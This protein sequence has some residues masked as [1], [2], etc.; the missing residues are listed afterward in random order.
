MMTRFQFCSLSTR[1]LFNGVAAMVSAAAISL[2]V[3]AGGE[4]GGDEISSLPGYG[5]GSGVGS[6]EIPSHARLTLRAQSVAHLSQVVLAD[7]GEFEVEVHP[8][9]DG[10]LAIYSGDVQL[11]L[12]EL[13]LSAAGVEV[14]LLSG[15]LG[16]TQLYVQSRGVS[17]TPMSLTAGQELTIPVQRMQDA[18]LLDG[19]VY[20]HAFHTLREHASFHISAG[21]GALLVA[22]DH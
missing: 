4:W 8:V 21:A 5:G 14:G 7:E 17:T 19:P 11:A 9:D 18:G 3:A 10:Y 1:K 20:L 13:L 22:Q 15:E 16:A 2:T 6:L 12:D